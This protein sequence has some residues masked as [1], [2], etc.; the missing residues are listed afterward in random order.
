MKCA[1]ICAALLCVLHGEASAQEKP[2][3][4][5][6]ATNAYQFDASTNTYSFEVRF[7]AV[8]C[9]GVSYNI[10]FNASGMKDSK[11]AVSHFQPQIDKIAA[12]V[13]KDER[14]PAH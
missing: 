9:A 1:L 8:P 12:D 4:Y 5:N 14:C 11:D 6:I 2:A 7:N 3:T 10:A 13:A